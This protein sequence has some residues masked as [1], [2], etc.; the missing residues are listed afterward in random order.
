MSHKSRKD[1]KPEQ[2]PP[3]EKAAVKHALRVYLKKTYW[4]AL[5]SNTEIDPQLWGWKKK[6]ELFEPVLTNKV[7]YFLGGLIACQ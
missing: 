1:L 6:N 5:S 7:S 2:L 3:T 4:K